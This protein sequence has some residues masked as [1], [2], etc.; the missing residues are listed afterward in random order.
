MADVSPT[1]AGPPVPAQELRTCTK[2]KKSLPASDFYPNPSD[3]WVDLS[4]QRRQ[5]H[6]RFCSVKAYL[7]LDP[8]KKLLYSARARAKK[9]NLECTI[10]LEDIVIPE[11][12]PIRKTPLR[13]TVGRGR[14]TGMLNPDAPSIDRINVNKG[15]VPGNIKVISW[16]ANLFKRNATSQE[17]A[18]M[19]LYM[20][21]GEDRDCKGLRQELEAF[22]ASNPIIS[23]AI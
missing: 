17:Y 11:I 12:C 4:G 1:P 9:K 19:L 23:V 21:D 15:Y 6:C 18:A 10:A 5:R 3:G 16:R 20:L 13:A 14:S 7:A 8:R 22:I 2:C